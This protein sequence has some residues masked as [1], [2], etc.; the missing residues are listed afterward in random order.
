MGGSLQ[1][2][3]GEYADRTSNEIYLANYATYDDL[4]NNI[5]APSSAYSTLNISSAFSVGGMAIAW[6]EEGGSGGGNPDGDFPDGD[7]GD[8]GGR[9]G[10][11]NDNPGDS[12]GGGGPD[13]DPGDG[14]GPGG[15]PIPEPTTL[16]LFALAGLG[17][18]AARRRRMLRQNS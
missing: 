8:G 9:G 16:S 2:V 11:P 4:L 1:P 15:T 3:A 13:D 14:G 18:L 7:S 6:Q 12:G 5:L 17:L 10:N